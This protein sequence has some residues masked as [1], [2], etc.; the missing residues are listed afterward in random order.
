MVGFAGY[1]FCGSIS[2]LYG[3][4]SMEHGTFSSKFLNR[5]TAV[6]TAQGKYG[7]SVYDT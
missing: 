5:V 3:I 2:R 1:V 4:H 7:G 6:R